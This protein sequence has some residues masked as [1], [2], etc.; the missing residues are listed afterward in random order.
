MRDDQP[1]IRAGIVRHVRWQGLRSGDPVAVN[2]DREYRRSWTF[3]AFARN[4]RTG[5]EWVE[6]RGGRVGES[7]GRAFRP[8]L[9]YPTNARRGARFKGL[10][11]RDAPQLG[12]D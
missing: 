1:T 12:F 9:I 3:V 5:E 4:E 7:K 8:E 6:V 11:F 10:S 2:A